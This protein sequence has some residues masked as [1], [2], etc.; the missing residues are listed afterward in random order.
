M[1]KR[2]VLYA[3]LVREYLFLLSKALTRAWVEMASPTGY[4]I[5]SSLA[6]WSATPPLDPAHILPTGPP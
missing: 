4:L 1:G 2:F 5:A 6:R 3:V